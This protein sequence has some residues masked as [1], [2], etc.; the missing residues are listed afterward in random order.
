MV[1]FSDGV[2]IFVMY[3]SVMACV[4]CNISVYIAF[5][6]LMYGVLA[7]DRHARALGFCM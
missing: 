2:C 3:V 1:S 4:F 7:L 5:H 6:A